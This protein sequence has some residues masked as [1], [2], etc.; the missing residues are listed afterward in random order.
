VAWHLVGSYL[1]T[2]QAAAGHPEVVAYWK[3]D[4]AGRLLKTGYDQLLQVDPQRP[5]P[6]IGPYSDYTDAIKNSLDRLVLQGDSVESVIARADEEI[7]DA[8]DRY[9]EDNG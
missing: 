4:L 1:P 5:G 6:Q 3:D 9:N 7:Q 2:T 8:L